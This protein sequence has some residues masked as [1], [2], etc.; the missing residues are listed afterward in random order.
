MPL[1]GL[2]RSGFTP[3]RSLVRVQC[4]P[5]VCNPLSLKNPLAQ[6]FEGA[7]LATRRKN[8]PG[9]GSGE[10]RELAKM[11]LNAAIP[12]S[13]LFA[14]QYNDLL[15]HRQPL[16]MLAER[17]HMSQFDSAIDA[18]Y[19]EELGRPGVN[20]RLMVCLLDLKHAY[21]ESDESVVA[22]WV[23]K[24][25]SALRLQELQQVMSTRRFQ[26]KAIA[27]PTDA[28]L[29]HKTRAALVR[30]AKSLGLELRQNYR[31]KAHSRRVAAGLRPRTQP[32]RARAGSH[33]IRRP[34]HLYPDDVLH[35]GQSITG[36]LRKRRRDQT[37]L[38]SFFHHA[39]FV[40]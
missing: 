2:N 36:S 5:L 38:R 21:G 23:E 17:I 25:H 28:R 9:F 27:F 35:L 39:E 31:V 13:E 33:E 12:Q 14:A 19:A 16:Y 10:P 8:L 40:L 11:K 29:H 30:R 24:P 34:G 26:E 3:Q 15:N 20:T 4:R 22:R 37:L 6:E 7:L 1:G 32:H 18:F